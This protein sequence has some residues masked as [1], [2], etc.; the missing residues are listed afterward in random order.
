MLCTPCDLK[1]KGCSGPEGLG[2]SSSSSH[3]LK[4][5]VQMQSLMAPQ[6]LIELHPWYLKNHE[7]GSVFAGERNVA[8]EAFFRGM[9]RHNYRVFMC[10]FMLC[11]QAPLHAMHFMHA[12]CAHVITQLGF[13]HIPQQLHS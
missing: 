10:V 7:E 5:V 8:M 1:V 9:W 12:Y 13:A 2:S 11:L 4:A 6:I 3:C